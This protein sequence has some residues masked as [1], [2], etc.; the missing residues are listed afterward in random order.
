MLKHLVIGSVSV[1]SEMRVDSVFQISQG[2]FSRF[3]IVLCHGTDH[4]SIRLKDAHDPAQ[5]FVCSRHSH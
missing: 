5:L 4:H 1:G 2:M 3:E